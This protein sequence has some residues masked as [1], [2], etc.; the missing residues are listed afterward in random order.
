MALHA[1]IKMNKNF[2][3][4]FTPGGPSSVD[5]CTHMSSSIRVH[6]STEI[7]RSSRVVYITRLKE[8]ASGNFSKSRMIFE[9]PKM[10]KM[11]IF[12]EKGISDS[13][14]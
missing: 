14:K 6:Y 1:R 8:I 11:T 13:G 5:S 12:E 4:F 2:F 7:E 10:A 3:I 9:I